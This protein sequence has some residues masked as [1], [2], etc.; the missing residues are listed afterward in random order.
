MILFIGEILADRIVEGK[1]TRLYLGGAPINAAVACAM[2]GGDAAFLG[3][4]GDDKTGAFLV[5]ETKKYP[6]RS[7]IQI[8]ENRATTVA[9]VSIDESGERD[10]KFLRDNT[11]DY[12]IDIDGV[13]S[14]KTDAVHLGSLM[15]GKE[16]GKILAGL[17]L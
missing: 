17:K 15:L 7:V 10:F 4:V 14:K 2:H 12:F 3:R 9:Q 16:E 1:E 8:D 11:A 5:E 13:F 6:L